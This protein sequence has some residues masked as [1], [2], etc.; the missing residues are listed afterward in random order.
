MSFRLKIYFVSLFILNYFSLNS[1]AV[2]DP[3]DQYVVLAFD[4][5][6]SLS[7]WEETR[8][9]SKNKGF[10]K[11]TYFINAAYYLR[12]AYKNVYEAPGLGRGQSAIGFGG[13]K[14]DV[15]SRF[16]QTN[17]AYDEGH[18]I[19]NHAAGHFDGSKW[20][21]THWKSE[22]NQFYDI[23]FRIFDHNEISE[24]ERPLLSW[25]LG[26]Q[27]IIGFR[28]P[29]L[30]RN[31]SMYDELPNQ[32]IKYDT[33]GTAAPN[34]WP[35]YDEKKDLWLFPLAEINVAG[36]KRKTLSMDYNFYYFQSQA[37]PE[38]SRSQEF[39]EQMFQSYINYF[40]S[41]YNG[42]RAP[43]NIGH[44][45]SKWNGGAYWRAMQRFAEY[46]CVLKNVKCVTYLTL[47]EEMN[48]IKGSPGLLASYQKGEFQHSNYP[49]PFERLSLSQTP[50]VGPEVDDSKLLQADPPEAHEE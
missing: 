1:W 36:T 15:L 40:F 20:Q 35:K 8:E 9:Y 41:N 26:R 13:T 23:L 32:G 12:D 18:E 45:F 3:P 28:A 43:I 34:Q 47:V 16:V 2:V 38:P 7:M 6:K 39:E 14:S 30:G 19:A 5:S 46:V 29:Q 48:R 21:A 11:F 24:N 33:S 10:V 50:S 42:N 27:D 37:Q 17:G 25:K 44:H 49:N 4:G 31:S 22:L